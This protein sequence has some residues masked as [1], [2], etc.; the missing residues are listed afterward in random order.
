MN[1][2]KL[3]AS[4]KCQ[5]RR[6]TE[7]DADNGCAWCGFSDIRGQGPRTAS[8]VKNHAILQR[9][10]VGNPERLLKIVQPFLAAFSVDCFLLKSPLFMQLPLP[11]E[12]LP[13]A[14]GAN[15]RA[16]NHRQSILDRKACIAP[17]TM[18]NSR[19]D[20][21][22]FSVGVHQGKSYAAIRTI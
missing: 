5:P 7:V 21:G 3:A 1:V 6:F 8:G 19:N 17:V 20:L 13:G 12:R 15:V 11:S 14:F 10:W 22:I 9:R 18:Q 16:E 4:F 2:R